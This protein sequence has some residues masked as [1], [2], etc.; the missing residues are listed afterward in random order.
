MSELQLC[1]LRIGAETY[2]VDINRV[3]EI[4]SVPPITT[5][6]GAPRFLKGLVRLRGDVV[7]VVDVRDR[8]GVESQVPKG[9]ERLVGV[10][11]WLA[12]RGPHRRPRDARAARLAREPSTRALERWARLDALRPRRVWRAAGAQADARREGLG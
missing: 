10:S 3:E 11:H 7:P 9:K 1:A 4:L 2:V 8:L 5:M 12:P 6:P